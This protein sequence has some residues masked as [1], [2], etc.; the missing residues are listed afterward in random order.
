MNQRSVLLV[1][2][3]AAAVG[4]PYHLSREHDPSQKSQSSWWE[5]MWTV[6]DEGAAASFPSKELPTARRGV[7]AQEGGPS[8]GGLAP[9]PPGPSG[10]PTTPLAV[11][12][13]APPGRDTRE[14]PAVQSLAE[15]LRFDVTPSW[16]M[17]QWPRVWTRFGQGDLAGWRVTLV[18]GVRLTDL[19][20]SLTYYF[21]R[22]HQLQRIAFDG[23]T[24]DASELVSILSQ[25]FGMRS[26]PYVGGYQMVARDATQTPFSA[27]RVEPEAL[28]DRNLPNQRYRVQMELNRPGIGVALGPLLFPDLAVSRAATGMSGLGA[29]PNG[30][31]PSGRIA[32]PA[33]KK[34][35]R[36]PADTRR[37]PSP[38]RLVPRSN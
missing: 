33:P 10:G 5:S 30:T 25:Y 15:L 37:L 11:P 29:G 12:S 9:N 17:A 28:L 24:G 6:A 3:V 4:I 23:V 2:T 1:A 19:A 14:G 18:S 13:P 20:G 35:D 34:P 21:D 7:W 36:K 31:G 27:L 38:R 16:V 26:E 8:V 32:A 22:Q